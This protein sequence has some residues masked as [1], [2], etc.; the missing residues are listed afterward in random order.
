MTEK[1][2]LDDKG[3]P[4]FDLQFY[5]V[6][7]KGEYARRLRVRGLDVRGVRREGCAS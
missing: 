4:Y 1:R 3:R 2:L 5:A 7:K 6:N